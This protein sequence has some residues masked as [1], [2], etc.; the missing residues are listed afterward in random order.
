MEKFK[1]IDE[2]LKPDPRTHAS[3]IFDESMGDFRQRE[4][5]DVHNRLKK[6]ILNKIVPDEIKNHFITSKHLVL[7]S[8]FVYRFIPVAELHAITSLEYALKFKTGKKKWGL[9]RLLTFAVKEGWV[10]DND[11]FIHRQSIERNKKHE[12]TLKK[13]LNIEPKEDIDP[14]EG[15]YTNALIESLPYLRNVY[16][17]GS[18]TIAP[19]GY[20][21]L[22]ICAEFINK[23]FKA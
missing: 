14:I 20:L 11:F 2:I 19:Q 21:T 3:R 13:Y 6:I 18:N 10:T 4:I 16:A 1:K 23:I 5:A 9:K 8:W 15:Q 7:Y 17:H 12:E 22:I